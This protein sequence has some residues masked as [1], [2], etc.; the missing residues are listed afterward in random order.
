MF[1][2]EIQHGVFLRLLEERHADAAFAAVE[3]DRAYL[4]RWL[5][6]VDQTTDVSYTAGFIKTSLEQFAHNEGLAAG[7]WCS[8]E[9]IGTV[10]THKIDWANRKVE[11]G[12]WIAS[13]YQGRGIITAGCSALIDH[14]FTEWKLN[15]VEIHCATSNDKSSAIPKRLGFQFEGVR[16]EGQRVNGEY[17]DIQVYALL[18]RE[19]TAR[20]PLFQPATQIGSRSSAP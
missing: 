5:P 19:W 20:A 16:R 4:R 10:G 18:F 8:E 13:R 9:F 7:I 2:K 3:R 6:W 1:Q 15:R 17:I 11:M 12:Y 14:A